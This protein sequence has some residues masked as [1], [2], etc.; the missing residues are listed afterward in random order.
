MP[1][2]SLPQLCRSPQVGEPPFGRN[3]PPRQGRPPGYATECQ[4]AQSERIIG[5]CTEK[6]VSGAV[7]AEVHLLAHTVI[8]PDTEVT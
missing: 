8:S 3:R 6:I 4:V 5:W 7:E 2:A 1:N